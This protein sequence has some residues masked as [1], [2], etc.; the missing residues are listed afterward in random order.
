MSAGNA[1]HC[2]IRWFQVL[3]DLDLKAA[4]SD[5]HLR[6]GR[7][8]KVKWA[9]TKHVC[10]R[11][12]RETK[13]LRVGRSEAGRRGK[14]SL[15]SSVSCFCWAQAFPCRALTENYSISL[16]LSSDSLKKSCLSDS[17]PTGD[18]ARAHQRLT[19]GSWKASAKLTVTLQESQNAL[20]FSRLGMTV[21]TSLTQIS[22]IS[23]H[24][25]QLFAPLS[26]FWLITQQKKKS[27][28]S[29]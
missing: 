11:R 17:G 25:G 6:D 5:A 24:T 26:G 8:Q 27:S 29:L 23:Y 28:V 22:V 9:V 12:K 1:R 2:Q 21:F 15:I 13:P 10:Q 16:H 3:I 20:V 7:A 14:K 18:Q 19:D 4:S